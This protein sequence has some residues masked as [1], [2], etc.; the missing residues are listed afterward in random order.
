VTGSLL[1]NL[2]RWQFRLSLVSQS[3]EELLGQSN[4]ARRG[5]IDF[6]LI[7]F[8]GAWGIWGVAWLM[9]A[10][11]TGPTGQVVVALGAFSP[12]LA[13]FVVR[14]WVTREGFADAGLGP[15]LRKAWP[16]FVAVW[17]LPLPV[18]AGIV[19]LAAALGISAVKPTLPPVLVAVAVGGALLTSPLFF[20]DELGWRGYLQI[21][22]LG[23]RPLP[24]AALT[25]VV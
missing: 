24:A 8:G 16:Y 19:V 18:I 15:N 4:S 10:F 5:I 11:N 25:G 6:L 13:T 17:L 23:G 22:L 1:N 2:P 21:R 3:Q 7:T 14:C 20:G 9:G 12:A